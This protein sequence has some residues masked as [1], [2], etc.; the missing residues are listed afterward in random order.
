MTANGTALFYPT[1]RYIYIMSNTSP[2]N[3][4]SDLFV[5]IIIIGPE[6][7]AN[8]FSISPLASAAKS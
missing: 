8:E 4:V 7:S 2:I 6:F 1:C 5:L 3:S